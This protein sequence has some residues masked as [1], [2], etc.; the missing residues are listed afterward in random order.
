VKIV[1]IE[2]HVIGNPWKNWVL[3]KVITDDGAMGWGDATSSSSSLAVQGAVKEISRFCIGK[4]PLSPRRVWEDMFIALNLPVRGTILSAMAGIETACWDIL[5]KS[6]GS[7]LHVLLGGKVNAK[8]KAYANGWYKGI[9]EPSSF[10]E[11]A[12]EVVERGYRALKFDP[13]GAAYGILDPKERRFVLAIIQAVRDATG[14][15]VDLLIETHDRLTVPEAIK[16]ADEL[17]AMGVTW[18][19]APV[20]AHDVAALVKVAESTSMRIVA[21]ERFTTLRAFADLLASGRIDVIQP[22]YIELGGVSRLVQAAA[23]AEAYQALIAPHNARSPLST[24]VNVHVDTAMRNVFLQETF[25]DFHVAWVDEIF[26]G[27]PVVIDG[28]FAASD[29]PGLGVSI[30]EKAMAKHPYSEKNHMRMFK[31]GWEARFAEDA[32]AA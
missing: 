4:D 8:I 2:T 21:G 19:E 22:E 25:N 9:R 29:A 3:V 10:A 6:L 20:W 13:F 16:I 26:E 30:N 11:R 31:S 14:P 12:V 1:S 17:D 18:M 7:P 15:D 27:L 23:I 32:G 5:G 24:A 28:C